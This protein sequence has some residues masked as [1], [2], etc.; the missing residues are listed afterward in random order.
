MPVP[1]RG[2][3]VDKSV[4]VEIEAVDAQTARA[5]AIRIAMSASLDHADVRVAVETAE[6]V[7]LATYANGTRD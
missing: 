1:I 6:G 3:P 5:E 4:I 7:V 2:R